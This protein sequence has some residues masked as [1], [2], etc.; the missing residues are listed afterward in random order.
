MIEEIGNRLDF[1]SLKAAIERSDAEALTEFYAEDTELRIVQ[2]AHPDGPA[3]ELKGKRQIGRYLRA[4][5]EQEMS[6]SVEEGAVVGEARIELVEA[7]SYPE[8][9]PVSIATTLEVKGGLIVR[10]T[11][12]VRRADRDEGSD[13]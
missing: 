9:P 12:V 5:C 1:G 13:R 8:G 4:V 3:F 11:A 7:I 6:C 10:H 2:A